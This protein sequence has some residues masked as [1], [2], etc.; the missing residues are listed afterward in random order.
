M[1]EITETEGIQNERVGSALRGAQMHPVDPEEAERIAEKT[2]QRAGRLGPL[3]NGLQEWM[4]GSN[5]AV[6][7]CHLRTLPVSPAA[8]GGDGLGHGRELLWSRQNPVGLAHR[9]DRDGV[10]ADIGLGELSREQRAS[11][12]KPA[13][14]VAP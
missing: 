1:N 3:Q 11:A 5:E 13:L 6:V 8:F 2:A 4:I 12:E 14:A 7:R 9:L 10:A